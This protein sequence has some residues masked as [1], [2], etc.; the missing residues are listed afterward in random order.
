[1]ALFA[2]WFT[3]ILYLSF[4]FK[5]WRAILRSWSMRMGDFGVLALLLPMLLATRFQPE[6]AV[7]VAFLLYL[8]IPTIVLRVRPSNHRPMDWLHALAIVSIWLPLEPSLFSMP[9][10]HVGADRLGAWVHLLALPDVGAPLLPGVN[11]P[12]DKL[13]GVLLALYLFL[14]RHPLQGVGFDFRLRLKD[15]GYAVVGWGMFG[16]VGIPLGLSMGFL[17]LHVAIPTWTELVA[18]AIGGY[19]LIALAEE[20]LFR[21][22]IQNLLAQRWGSWAGALAVAALIFGASHLNNATP[23]FAE[24]NWA[25]MLMATLAGLAYG[26]VW[27][28]SGRVTVS[29]LTHMAVNFMWGVFFVT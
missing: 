2:A 5:R 15:L 19:L 1:M 16:V 11:L 7:L 6:P 25:Y 20:I 13:T 18:M 8:L 23:G 17:K 10:A 24:P 3:L 14:I 26:W 29:A 28:K 22:I 21:G 12:I 27:W 9:L 4:A